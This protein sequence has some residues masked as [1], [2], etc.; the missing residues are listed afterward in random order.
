MK[1]SENQSRAINSLGKNIVVSA[2]AGA[3]K[4]AV[5]TARLKKRITVDKVSVSNILAMTF[6]DAAACEMKIRLFKSLSELIDSSND[7]E[8]IDY[9]NQQ[10][11]L[12]ATS[13]VSTIHS[14]CLSVIKEN[15]YIINL[16][17]TVLENILSDDQLVSIHELVFK[18]TF[19]YFNNIDSENLNLLCNYFSSSPTNF[20][21]LKEY[22]KTIAIKAYG[23]FNPD[24]YF[25]N[26]KNSYIKINNIKEIEPKY[27]N[28]YFDSIRVILNDLASSLNNCLNL[29][30]GCN[31]EKFTNVVSSNIEKVNNCI[32]LLNIE[33]YFEF[34]VCHKNLCESILPIAKNAELK[35]L[36]ASINDKIKKLVSSVVSN[37]M[38]VINNNGCAEIINTLTDFSQKYLQL[39]NQ[40]KK[41]IDAMD[42]NDMEKFAYQILS[43]NNQSVAKKY[44]KRF[45]DILVDE[46][47]DTN[48]IQNEIIIMI[49]RGN[50]I[51]RVGDVKQSI[52]RFRN[53]KP[54]IMAKLIENEDNTNDVIYLNENYR[55]KK[56]IVEYNNQ[57][58]NILMNVKGIN[59]TY[60]KYDFVSIGTLG[61]DDNHKLLVEFASLDKDIIEDKLDS[62]DE[63]IKD[64]E[65]DIV[66]DIKADYIAKKIMEMRIDTEFKNFSDYCI[67]VRSHE[68]KNAIRYAFDHYNI[69]Y[70]MDVKSGFYKSKVIMDILEF[71]RFI[72]NPNDLSIVSLLSSNFYNESFE[73]ITNY[74]LKK[75]KSTLFNYL[76]NSENK[77]QL[78]KD[79]ELLKKASS[80]DTI[81]KLVTK[82]ININNYF[83]DYTTNQQRT[84]IDLFLE[85]ISLYEKSN[86]NSLSLYMSYI[87]SISDLRS[88]EAI[89]ENP[90]DDTVKIMTV[91]HSKGL[92]FPVVFYWSSSTTK[93]RENYL[94]D[95]LGIGLS[96]LTYPLRIQF[97]T[98]QQIAIRQKNILEE[99]AESTR[100]LYVALTRAQQK[101]IMI[102][103][104]N[105][106][107]NYEPISLN[108][109]Y[110]KKGFTSLI[111]PASASI[112]EFYEYKVIDCNYK[113]LYL[114]DKLQNIKNLINRY[115]QNK[116]ILNRVSPSIHFKSKFKLNLNPKAYTHGNDMHKI[117]EL[118]PKSGWSPNIIKSLWDTISDEDII[119]IMDL[120]NNDLFHSLINY[121]TYC[122]YKYSMIKNTDIVNGII[123]YFA[124]N[125]KSIVIIDF[126]SDNIVDENYYIENYQS[127]LIQ[128]KEDMK[129][130]YPNHIIDTY[131]YSFTLNQMIK[132]D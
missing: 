32:N 88:S 30:M 22:T 43:F 3:G 75:D 119:K 104:H 129:I 55:S 57:L 108:T 120:Y 112:N 128:Y 113:I 74:S 117:I 5:L 49:S 59:Q 20:D 86:S 114:N 62:D 67:L 68:Y 103:K 111:L 97:D 28:L 125:D 124:I 10:L 107:Y 53:A 42:F 81:F 64:T 56:S 109:F 93:I 23:S 2:S 35:L 18:Q 39:F 83:E 15:Y 29:A 65:I 48:D 91:H 31:E 70:S 38:A 25:D 118:L 36:R 94:D 60:N 8:E 33:S 52:Y 4:T 79:Y 54:M 98:I 102:D 122:E 71:L 12:L 73:T 40:H 24:D 77:H 11:I 45:I 100:L 17:P 131:I 14:F 37:E 80:T 87:N 84:N 92:Q 51:F 132:I 85:K 63:E 123:D 69:P 106:N 61:Q 6:T 19:E 13:N 27:L 96:Y 127:Q 95:N 115:K 89:Y 130:I 16:A 76:S 66:G 47:Q 99:F 9:C 34:Y 110:K 41:E 82:I 121:E 50:N 116:V 105:A 46:F 7:Q 1:Y 21:T 90:S 101:L 78:I 26:M 72:N 44:Q 126:K 58:F